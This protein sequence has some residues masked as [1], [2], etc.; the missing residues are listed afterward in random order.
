MQDGNSFP[1]YPKQ[2]KELPARQL[3]SFPATGPLGLVTRLWLWWLRLYMNRAR[4][5]LTLRGRSAKTPTDRAYGGGI[6]LNRAK[7][8]GLYIDDR[9]QTELDKYHR[10]IGEHEGARHGANELQREKEYTNGLISKCSR[11]T[12][13]IRELSELAEERAQTIERITERLNIRTELLRLLRVEL[14]TKWIEWGAGTCQDMAD[15]F[16]ANG[17]GRIEPPKPEPLQPPVAIDSLNAHRE[18][19]VNPPKINPPTEKEAGKS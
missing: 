3:V 12:G 10:D 9:F 6:K 4:Y 1:S 13:Q 17:Y 11:K 18:P 5:T 15:I 7:R 2:T 8:W 16:E 19:Y 14:S